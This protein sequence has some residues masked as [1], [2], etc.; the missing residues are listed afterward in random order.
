MFKVLF[1]HK[2]GEIKSHPLTDP[3]AIRFDCGLKLQQKT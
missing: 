1:I 3:D 2:N